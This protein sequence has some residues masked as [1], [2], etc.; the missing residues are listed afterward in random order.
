MTRRLTDRV[1]A[2]VGGGSGMGR[3]VSLRLAEEGAH[4]YVADLSADAAKTA[5][6]GSW[7]RDPM[8]S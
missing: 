2:V 7:G 6:I 3:A 5:V 4:V 1:A 8:W